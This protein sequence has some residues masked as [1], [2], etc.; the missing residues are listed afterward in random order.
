MFNIHFNERG[1]EKWNGGFFF[2]WKLLGRKPCILQLNA[3]KRK[4]TTIYRIKHLNQMP[5]KSS[6]NSKNK[7]INAV[8]YREVSQYKYSW[9]KSGTQNYA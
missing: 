3:V 2:L 1:I 7:R 6:R 8:A 9:L 5:C 4:D